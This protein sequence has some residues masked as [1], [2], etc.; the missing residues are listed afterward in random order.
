M[1]KFIVVAGLI[2]GLTACGKSKWDKALS[3]M[4]DERDAVCKCAD[5]KCARDAKK[6]IEEKLEAIA[7]DMGKDEEPPK[8]IMEKGDKIEKEMKEC[9]KKLKDADKGGADA[10]KT[11]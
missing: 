6:A 11:P 7:K 2:A 8:D 5:V 4:E 9:M 10:P 1:R 3:L